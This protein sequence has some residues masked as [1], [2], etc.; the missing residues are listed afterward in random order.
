MARINDVV[1]ECLAVATAFSSINSQTY[2]EIGAIN[3]EDNDKT[4][5]LFLFNKSGI[6]VNVV[7]YSRTNL[8]SKSIYTCNL[9]FLDTYTESEKTT[10][11]LQ[12]KQNELMQY[13]EQYFAELRRRNATGVN[14][15]QLGEVSFNSNDEAHNDR[16]V[17][18]SYNVE[19]IVFVENCTLG[20]FS[21][22][23]L[24]KPTSLDV[25]ATTSSAITL[26]WVDNATSET[27]Y[28]VYRSTNGTSFSLLD[29]IAANS[30]SYTDSGL[31]ANTSYLYKVRAIN[32]NVN[33]D[34]S[35]IV[36]GCTTS[37]AV[38]QSGIAYQQI[39]FSGQTT[40][41]RTY[42][43]S[44]QLAN[45]ILTRTPPT[46]PQYIAEYDLT[47]V[48]PFYTLKNN[49]AFGNTNVWTDENGL[50]VYGNNYAINHI[51]GL[52]F[53]LLQMSTNLWD[54]VVTEVRALNVLGYT[55]FNLSSVAILQAIR[56]YQGTTNYTDL[57]DIFTSTTATWTATS[58]PSS[59]NFISILSVG[60]LD[61]QNPLTQN[62]V[63][64]AFRKHY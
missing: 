19:F 33:G 29:T 28:E 4:Y 62:Y 15:F 40:S 43:E 53:Y 12:T 42:D 51:Y 36:V 31:T 13:A 2:N 27:N 64:I 17:Q 61:Q 63:G 18:L 21:Y 34:F 50:Q 49:N 11:A 45:G 24:D 16:L 7:K 25:S 59:T 22:D 57:P 30:T 41:R 46:N 14:G 47:D 55:D 44:W 26:S 6:E 8:P 32:A 3:F 54:D 9:L 35:N 56:D 38:S 37:V 23:G 48:N 5:P 20:S 58:R 60:R 10:T 1:D 39:P 52:G